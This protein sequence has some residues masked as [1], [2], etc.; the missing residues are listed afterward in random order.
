MNLL[1][2]DGSSITYREFFAFKKRP[3]TITL[4]NGTELTTSAVFSFA[5]AIIY[6]AERNEYSFYI[7][8]WDTPPYKKK[9][10]FPDYKEGRKRDKKDSENLFRE[11]DMI[12]ILANSLNIPCFYSKGYEAEDVCRSVIKRIGKKFDEI[13]ILAN[14]ND[15]NSLLSDKISI[16]KN[17]REGLIKFTHDD[18]KL[19]GIDSKTFT[20]A[21]KLSGCTTDKVK[22]FKGIGFKTAVDLIRTFGSA[23]A[24]FNNKSELPE[25]ISSKLEKGGYDT[26][27][28]TAYLIKILNPKKLKLHKSDN[29]VSAENMLEFIEAE[30]LLK[31]R[32]LLLLPKLAKQQAK[33]FDKL[34]KKLLQS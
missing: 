22:G 24:V 12:K 13:T 2:I 20:E 3:L 1:I 21:K 9:L 16:L 6:M 28:K 14:D 32:F 7:T 33:M 23:E 25:N 34:E 5:K 10:K 11:M 4:E 31:P 30:S 8:T 26:L 15:Y 29:E 27:E 17:G 18:L 19:D